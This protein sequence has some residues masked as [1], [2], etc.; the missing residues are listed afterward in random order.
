ML[1]NL[2]PLITIYFLH[3][4]YAERVVDSGFVHLIPILLLVSYGLHTW[5]L[6]PGQE[7]SLPQRTLLWVVI[8]ATL[9]ISIKLLFSFRDVYTTCLNEQRGTQISGLKFMMTGI[10]GL[11]L[12][13]V[14]VFAFHTL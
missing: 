7:T 1:T 13:L 12:P 4:L 14:I 9:L 5:T 2:I 8:L 11:I 3:N 10:L 6:Q